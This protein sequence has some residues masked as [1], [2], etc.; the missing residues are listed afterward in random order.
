[1]S[2]PS[3][4]DREPMA[5]AGAAPYPRI[6]VALCTHNGAEFLAAQLRSILGQTHPVDEIVLSDDASIDGTVALVADGI[7]AHAR[8]AVRVPSLVV[9][10]NEPALGVVRNFEQA[11]LRCTGDVIALCD[12]DD[13]WHEDRMAR[14]MAAFAEHPELLLVH[15]DA[16]LIRA[17]GLPF[18]AGLAA[19][20]RMSPHERH[21]LSTNRGWDV[22]VRRS[23]VTGATVVIRRGLLDRAVPFVD[24]WVHDEWLAIMAAATGGTHFLDE[25][26]LDYR[27]HARNQIG[28]VRRGFS[29][30]L[31]RLF[32]PRGERNERLVGRAIDLLNRV[33][34]LHRAAVNRRSPD[35]RLLAKA[36]K[37]ARA[38]LAHER[39]RILLPA[40]RILRV[41]PVFAEALT[42]RYER[43]G[44]GV[45]DIARDL[46]QKAGGVRETTPLPAALSARRD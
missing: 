24:S 22:L 18:G 28:V 21:S 36:V 2:D 20:Q 46:L 12:Q 25:Q 4:P 10:E 19:T 44:R 17:D 26:L 6:S 42:G 37:D 34:E 5:D 27:Q 31:A 23:L 11:L 1:M 32:T 38:K 3:A 15:S 41:G 29:A 43:Y 33:T 40:V 14:V 8:R 39:V 9:I 35:A 13:V 30:R 45:Q 7:A 16:R